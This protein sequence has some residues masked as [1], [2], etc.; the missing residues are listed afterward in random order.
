MKQKSLRQLAQEIG[1]SPAYLS[2]VMTGKRPA[3]KKV[4]SKLEEYLSVSVKQSV[5]QVGGGKSSTYNQK[6]ESGGSAWESNPPK[7]LLMPPNG[8]E[9]R[10]AHRDSSAPE[11][12]G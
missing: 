4:L 12:C 6:I 11:R 1:V 2:Q 7:T 9:V 10:E 5:K 3:S 8:F